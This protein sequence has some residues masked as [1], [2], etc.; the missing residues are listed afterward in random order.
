MPS[1]AAEPEELIVVEP[2]RPRPGGPNRGGPN[3]F[4]PNDH[5]GGG[6]DDGEPGDGYTPGLS[7]LGMRLMLVSIATLFV[8]LAIV[9]LARSRSPKFWQ[10]LNPPHL[11][12]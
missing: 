6:G 1:A 3:D 7:M 11:L 2:P 4:D 12:W 5:G 8:V 10:P 9:F